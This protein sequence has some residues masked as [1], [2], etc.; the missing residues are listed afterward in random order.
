M[1]LI[2]HVYKDA[3][4]T[5][6]FND[7]VDVLGASAVN[8]SFDDGVFYVGTPTAA[9]KIEASS[10]PGIDT[11][12]VTPNDASPGGGVET[13]DVKLALTNGGLDAAIGGAALS[14]GT[15]ING[16]AGN[17]VAVHYRWT[18]NVGGSV[19]TEITLDLD[20]RVETLA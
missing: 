9:N 19:Y 6:Q 2:A 4:L 7:S 20:A 15:V 16:G 13:T 8:G 14:L 5:Q 18:N 10:D 17:A 1:P 11:I 3:A 12:D